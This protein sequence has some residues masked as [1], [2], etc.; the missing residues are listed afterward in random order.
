MSPSVKRYV[1]LAA[2]VVANICQGVAYTSSIFMRPLGKALARPEAQW[3][4][5]W[6]FIFAMTLACLPVG[7][8][9]SGKLADLGRTRLTIGL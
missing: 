3:P 5:E 4:S 1:I 6:G 9:L 7:M 8:L 2:G